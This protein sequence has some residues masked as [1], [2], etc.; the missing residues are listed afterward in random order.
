MDIQLM[1]AYLDHVSETRRLLELQENRLYSLLVD[2]RRAQMSAPRRVF[3]PVTSTTPV[4]SAS[5]RRRPHVIISPPTTPPRSLST[6][7]PR[8]NESSDSLDPIQTIMENFFRGIGIDIS[9]G[10][11]AATPSWWEPVTVVPTDDEISRAVETLQFSDVGDSSITLCP[12]TQTEFQATDEVMRIRACGHVFSSEGL[13]EWFAR[14]VRCPMCRHDIR[15]TS[16]DEVDESDEE[17]TT[18]ATTPITHTTHPLPVSAAELLART[19]GVSNDT[20]TLDISGAFLSG[21]GRY[22]DDQGDGSITVELTDGSGNVYHRRDF[23]MR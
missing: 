13:R 10:R 6:T 5:F 2:S 8:R 7:T 23:N 12:I 1:R 21:F 15:E 19:F 9:G 20:G 4:A 16:V 22:M 17:E 11:T 14:S 3:T 18:P